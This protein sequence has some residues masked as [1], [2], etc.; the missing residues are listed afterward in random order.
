MGTEM[1]NLKS[2]IDSAALTPP[3]HT[4]KTQDWPANFPSGKSQEDFSNLCSVTKVEDLG[5]FLEV[6][7]LQEE[8]V[9]LER[10]LACSPKIQTPLV[11]PL[12]PTQPEAIR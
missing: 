7:S 11:L 8:N 5:L 12:H 6:V 10:N 1:N 2:R 9:H 4:H 3:T